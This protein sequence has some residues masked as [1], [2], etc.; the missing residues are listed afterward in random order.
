MNNKKFITVN[1]LVGCIFILSLALQPILISNIDLDD[2]MLLANLGWRGINGQRPVLDFPH[3][4]SGVAAQYVSWAFYLFDVSF[5]AINF[6]LLMMFASSFTIL[7]ILCFRR[8]S[9]TRFS[10]LGVLSAALTISLVPLEVGRIAVPT[11]GHSFS[12]NHF[13][14]VIMMALT[15]FALIK[16]KERNT[17]YV[18]AVFAGFAVAVLILLKPTFSVFGL[19]VLLACMSQSRWISSVLIL[20]GTMLSMT[21]LDPG[22]QRTLVRL[23][24]Y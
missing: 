8:L 17:E 23:I 9:F 14:I 4:Y 18:C 12:Y 2:T 24:F 22:M 5:R 3:L 6:A 11:I 7:G 19:A 13:A 10:I 15:V 1:A 21:I 20:F 16:V